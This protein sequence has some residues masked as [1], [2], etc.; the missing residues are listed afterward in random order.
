MGSLSRR[1]ALQNDE[2]AVADQS[3]SILP[4]VPI[5]VRRRSG[6]AARVAITATVRSVKVWFDARMH[7][8]VWLQ[9]SAPISRAS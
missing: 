8:G 5:L 1:P 9:I 7:T 6:D 4:I 2:Q 3:T